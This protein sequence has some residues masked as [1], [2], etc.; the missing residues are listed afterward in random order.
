MDSENLGVMARASESP[1]PIANSGGIEKSS[2][3]V[4]MAMETT[5]GTT[6]P[7]KTTGDA[8]AATGSAENPFLLSSPNYKEAPPFQ[9]SSPLSARDL[10]QEAGDDDEEEEAEMESENVDNAKPHT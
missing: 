4:S 10:K 7:N 3:D 2:S 9:P 8:A 5:T 1:S 6:T